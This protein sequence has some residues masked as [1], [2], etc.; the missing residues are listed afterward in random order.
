MRFPSP[1]A[2][3]GYGKRALSAVRCNALRLRSLGGSLVDS[4][5]RLSTRPWRLQLKPFLQAFVR[6]FLLLGFVMAFR[7]QKGPKMS[8]TSDENG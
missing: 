6:V 3:S 5:E 2:G 1:R 7:T 8:P 4:Q